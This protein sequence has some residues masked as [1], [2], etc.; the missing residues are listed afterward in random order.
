MH[1]EPLSEASD[2]SQLVELYLNPLLK[3][4]H[5]N[6]VT[7]KQCEQALYVC[8]RLIAPTGKKRQEKVY[9]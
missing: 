4:L 3:T 7:C 5:T 2:G 9:A 6:K 8:W 1:C